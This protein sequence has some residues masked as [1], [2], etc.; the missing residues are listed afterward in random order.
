MLRAA[1][2]PSFSLSQAGA[3]LAAMTWNFFLNNALTFHDLRLHGANLWSGLLRFYVLCAGG[4]AWSEAV[5][6]GLH[7]W[8]AHWLIAGMTGAVT[9]SFWNYW[10][11]SRTTWESRTQRTEVASG[12]PARTRPSLSGT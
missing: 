9:A 8:G 3:I 10:S 4:A 11:T 7:D 1:I 6:T 12:K 2:S 5:G